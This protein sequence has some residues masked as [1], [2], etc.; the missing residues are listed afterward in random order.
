DSSF[1][2][3]VCTRIS[4]CAC[5]NALA[6]DSEAIHSASRCF[7]VF[8]LKYDWSSAVM[9]FPRGGVS[10]RQREHRARRVQRARLVQPVRLPGISQSSETPL[11]PNLTDVHRPSTRTVSAPKSACPSLS[12]SHII[13][14]E[15]SSTL[16]RGQ[17]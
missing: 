11:R 15:H 6:L 4:T 5:S 3:S 8:W 1:V 9:R 10:L 12:R 2:P 14:L 16:T 7:Q 17:S 13:A